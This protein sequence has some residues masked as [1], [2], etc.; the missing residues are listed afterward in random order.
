MTNLELKCMALRLSSVVSTLNLSEDSC[1]FLCK[2]FIGSHLAPRCP[3]WRSLRDNSSPSATQPTC[4][5]SKCLNNLSKIDVLLTDKTLLSTK[6]I[7]QHLLKENSSPPILPYTWSAIL[8]PG[9]VM[10]DHWARVLDPFTENFK[11]NLLWSITLRGVKVRNSLKNWGYIASDCCA[12]CNRK[13]TIDH[14]FLNCLRVKR[15]W[16][17]FVPSLSLLLEIPFSA[18]VRTVFFLQW[19]S[20]HRKK[21]AIGSFLI[22]SI[23]Y[24]I[25]TFRNKTTFHNGNESY[26]AIIKYVL[27]DISSRIKLDSFRL[28]LSHF[29]ALWISPGFSSVEHDTLRIFLS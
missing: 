24:A 5:Y 11:N 15:V 19:P 22:K 10:K 17:H 28:S 18:N 4:F 27:H 13:E 9:F 20:H 29:R 8:G 26:K 6:K 14:C 25:W 21:D 12:Y 2:Y 7:Y 3:E 1:F 23:V 16:S